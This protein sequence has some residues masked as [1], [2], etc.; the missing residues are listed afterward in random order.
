MVF[1]QAIEPATGGLFFEIIL[2][3]SFD[4]LILPFSNNFLF[5][6]NSYL[7]LFNTSLYFFCKFSAISSK[8]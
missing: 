8:V 5:S 3:S 4:S 1:A 7:Y 2:N 6:S